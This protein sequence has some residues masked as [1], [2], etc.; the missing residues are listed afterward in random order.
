MRRR[1]RQSLWLAAA[2]L[3]ALLALLIVF[4]RGLA[5][6][7]SGHAVIVSVHRGDTVG[8]VLWQL[9]T[10]RA[11]K[12][13]RWARLYTKL[14][15]IEGH[16]L[17]PGLYELPPSKTTP[18]ILRALIARLGTVQRIT[19]PEGRNVRW[20]A[21]LL[22]KKHV[23]PRSEFLG[24]CDNPGVFAKDVTFHLP[25][26][27]LEGYL[28]PDT[29]YMAENLGARKALTM[30]L[31]N[32]DRRVHLAGV[33]PAD[34]LAYVGKVASLIE[35]EA[36][37]PKDRPLIAGVIRNRLTKSM[38]LQIDAAVLY[39]MGLWKDR[40]LV[41]DL[42][43][44]TPYNTYKHPGLPPTPICNPGIAS[45]QA[46]A[47]PA[48]HNYLYYVARGDGSHAFAATYSEHLH[49]KRLAQQQRDVAH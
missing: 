28:F 3:V 39:G 21:A 8:S 9:Q 45:L 41:R 23:C 30:M 27:G 15:G 48:T 6:V 44:D 43:R 47:K 10:H 31:Q 12:S 29:Y 32:F 46:A 24:A 18:E 22:D 25:D 13:A 19:I 33:L 16:W 5:P 2:L 37:G 42:Q 35:L 38:P 26:N 4:S 1:K 7:G 40:V 11:I 14:T 20:I 17:V 36:K 34:R 49:N